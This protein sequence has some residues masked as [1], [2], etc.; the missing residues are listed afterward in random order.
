MYKLE[1]V[2]WVNLARDN[3]LLS[4][5]LD[6]RCK[7]KQAQPKE[8]TVTKFRRINYVEAIS[9]RQNGKAVPMFN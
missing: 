9:I 8:I 7:T 3:S 1:G 6:E 5:L 4:I 2:V